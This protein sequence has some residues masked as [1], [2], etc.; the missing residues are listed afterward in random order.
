M[1]GQKKCSV[2]IL[3]RAGII[4][5]EGSVSLSIDSEMLT[6]PEF[7]IVIFLD[8]IKSETLAAQGLSEE[9]LPRIRSNITAELKST[10]IL[11]E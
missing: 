7:D 1:F 2:K 6:G 9:D 5:T 11:W 4:Y 10:K 3:G 8:K